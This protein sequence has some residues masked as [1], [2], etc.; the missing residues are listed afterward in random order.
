M[1]SPVV[2]R[3]I[4]V[5]L[6]NGSYPFVDPVYASNGKLKPLYAVVGGREERHPEGVYYLRYANGQR[7]V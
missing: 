2:R 6:Q 7:R 3:K 1:K 4:R 5:R